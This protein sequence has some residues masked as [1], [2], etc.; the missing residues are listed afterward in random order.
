M[1]SGPYISSFHRVESLLQISAKDG[2]ASV[3]SEL[4]QFHKFL[5]AAWNADAEVKVVNKTSIASKGGCF[6]AN[7]EGGNANKSFCN[8]EVAKFDVIGV[9]S[10]VEEAAFEES[11]PR[12]KPGQSTAGKVFNKCNKNSPVGVEVVGCF[13]ASSHASKVLYE[14][15]A[16]ARYSRR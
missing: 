14:V 4:I 10:F 2:E 12:A 3:G 7:H 6:A 9:P 5:G 16:K 8:S 11:C 15:E 1:N 13:M